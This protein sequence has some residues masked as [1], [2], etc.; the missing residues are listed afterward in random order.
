MPISH[1]IDL[2]LTFTLLVAYQV[3]QFACDYLL[4][5]NEMVRL[6]SS[7]HWN[8]FKPL[9][10]HTSMHG[11]FS[12]GIILWA[13]PALWWLALGDLVI[14]FIVDRLKS[15]PR[16]LGRFNKLDSSLFWNILGLDQMIHHLTHI[17]IIY[18]LVR[19]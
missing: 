4:Q 13:N 19:M 18:I 10:I 11:L 6:K 3:K 14:H 16:Y 5:T 8:F 12:L 9:L 1:E 2:N 7:P 17:Y 15:G